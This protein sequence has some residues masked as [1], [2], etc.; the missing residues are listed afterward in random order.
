MNPEDFAPLYVAAPAAIM[1]A[2]W[3]IRRNTAPASTLAPYVPQVRDPEPER[4]HE[5][6]QR[7][8]E[9][10]TRQ[11]LADLRAVTG[12]QR[13]RVD[14]PRSNI[15]RVRVGAITAEA[16]TKIGALTLARM[17]ALEFQREARRSKS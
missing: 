14:Q 15:H 7:A 1:L 11:R 4:T 5:D 13:I 3:L 2:A 8:R 17:R 10:H 12:R 6:Y 16:R 9:T